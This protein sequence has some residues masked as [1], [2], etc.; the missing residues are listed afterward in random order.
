[1]HRSRESNYVLRLFL[2]CHL[3]CPEWMTVI[4]LWP[5]FSFS[6]GIFMCAHGNVRLNLTIFKSICPIQ[7]LLQGKASILWYALKCIWFQSIWELQC[8]LGAFRFS[9]CFSFNLYF[10][11]ITYLSNSVIPLGH[12]LQHWPWW[13]PTRCLVGDW[14]HHQSDPCSVVWSCS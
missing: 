9:V 12:W 3:I 7:D 13:E 1:M 10:S 11:K 6:S 4:G 14:E 5:W 2:A 8:I